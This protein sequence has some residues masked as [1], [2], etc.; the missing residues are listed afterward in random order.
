MVAWVVVA[1]AV[2]SGLPA[3]AADPELVVRSVAL[4]R[5]TVRVS[6]L[7]TV[8]V[9]VTVQASKTKQN[10]DA[11][12]IYVLFTRTAGQEPGEEAP[13]S[14]LVELTLSA[15]TPS[16]GT[17]VGTTPIPSTMN[18]TFAVTR[19]YPWID[20]LGGVDVEPVDVDGPSLAVVGTHIP[21]LTVTNSPMPVPVGARTYRFGGRL[22]DRDT[23]AGY[24][25]PVRVAIGTD[26][27]CVESSP[28]ESVITDRRGY[29]WS[30]RSGDEKD[31]LHCAA[32][33]PTNH[34][35]T[36]V[37][38]RGHWIEVR[39]WVH[40]TPATSRARV[41]RPVQVTGSVSTLR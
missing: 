12:S 9:R 27:V 40:A 25:K 1:G 39:P 24:G 29:F 14:R 13:E 11:G 6:G 4:D 16:D 2:A 35:I 10:V 22:V 38:A 34:W 5:S 37:V 17:F 7:A 41:G 30:R 26:S 20:F 19:V 31:L 3:R 15:G 8:P 23:G 32:I 28:S 36:Y 21:K 33:D 18:G